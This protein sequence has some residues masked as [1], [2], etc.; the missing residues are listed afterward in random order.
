MRRSVGRKV[1][2]QQYKT[3][4][5]RGVFTPQKSANGVNWLLCFVPG[6]TILN[7]Y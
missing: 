5:L 2:R 1:P 7:T 4:G 6:G 3:M